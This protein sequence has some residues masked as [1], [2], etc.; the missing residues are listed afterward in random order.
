MVCFFH[1][2]IY[3][4]ASCVDLGQGAPGSLWMK[5]VARPAWACTMQWPMTDGYQV[6]KCN[7]TRAL[8]VPGATSSGREQWGNG[9]FWGGYPLPPN[10]TAPANKGHGRVWSCSTDS[11]GSHGG[12]SMAQHMQAVDCD[13]ATA[14]DHAVTTARCQSIQLQSI[15]VPCQHIWADLHGNQFQPQGTPMPGPWGMTLQVTTAC[16]GAPSRQLQLCGV[17]FGSQ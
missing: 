4:H 8:G 6:G 2:W 15:S 5:L 17:H 9:E 16:H 7:H 11:F 13:S 12:D 1:K 14:M 10:S 3:E